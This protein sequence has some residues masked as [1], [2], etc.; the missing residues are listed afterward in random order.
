VKHLREHHPER[1]VPSYGEFFRERQEARYK[2]GGGRC[3]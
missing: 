2:G 3:C 1:K